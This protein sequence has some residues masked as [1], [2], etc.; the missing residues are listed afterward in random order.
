MKTRNIF[1]TVV[2]LS[3]VTALFT[4]CSEI[5]KKVAMKAL[6]ESADYEKAD[7]VKWGRVVEQDLDLPEFT[8]IDAK[9]AVRIVFLQDTTCAVRVRG[10]EKCIAE[11][12]FAVRKDE[13]KVEPRGFNGSVKKGSPAVT[14]YVSAPNLSDIEFAGAGELEM[15]DATTLFGS[16]DIEMEGAGK[17]SVNDLTVESLNIEVSG[18][19]KCTLAKVV[20]S[21]DI[22]IEVNGAGDVNANVF[23]QEL[24][25]ELNGAGMA[26]LSG[27]CKNFV[28]G[29]NGA[30][31]VDASKLKR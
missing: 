15:P 7:T 24:S 8:T 9:G 1:F 25:V 27:E 4:S 18:A 19:G 3:A 29:E 5:A 11:Y 10:N 28:C 17:I 26:V 22:E 2:L 21:D 16:L 12:K 14:L 13:L 23:C 6:E 31:K 30:S 20:A